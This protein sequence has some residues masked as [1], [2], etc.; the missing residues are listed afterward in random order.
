MYLS[1]PLEK[2][3]APYYKKLEFLSPKGALYRMILGKTKMWQVSD[4]IEQIS[5]RKFDQSLKKDRV[6]T[7]FSSSFPGM[8]SA[9]A[10]WRRHTLILI[11]YKRKQ[12]LINTP[13][14]NTSPILRNRQLHLI[15]LQPAL[16]INGRSPD[17]PP[18]LE[19]GSRGLSE[20]RSHNEGFLLCIVFIMTIRLDH[21]NGQ[22]TTR[23]LYI[24]FRYHTCTINRES[25][26]AQ[27]YT[28]FGF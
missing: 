9:C 15:Y 23:L 5:I 21:R 27:N 16:L 11:L 2:D 22:S 4:K 26:V 1:H 12:K 8:Q 6:V 14:C 7:I 24:L 25:S 20:G 19:G 3:V 10:G 28:A 13:V 17:P 18:L